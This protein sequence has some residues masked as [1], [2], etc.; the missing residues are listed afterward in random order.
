MQK[1]EHNNLNAFQLFVRQE[2]EYKG[3]PQK[4]NVHVPIVQPGRV[5]RT[6]SP[7]IKKT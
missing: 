4:I 2:A 6:T 5:L 3:Q 1:Q 7:V